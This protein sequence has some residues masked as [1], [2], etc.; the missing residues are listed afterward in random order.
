MG[1]AAP[2][3]KPAAPRP[4]VLIDAAPGG[5]AEMAMCIVAA[6]V[7]VLLLLS[8]C[9][10]AHVVTPPDMDQAQWDT[11]EALRIPAKQWTELEH[12]GVGQIRVELVDELPGKLVGR[13]HGDRPCRPWVEVERGAPATVLAHEIGHI[14]LALHSPDAPSGFMAPETDGTNL[15]IVEEQRAL[16][17]AGA[18]FLKL[19]KRAA[20]RKA[21]KT[22]TPADATP[23]T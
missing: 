2:P 20:D 5:L 8:G 9:A 10:T 3:P 17:R 4:G 23:A 22:A 21:R 16:M 19:C 6:V 12:G 18:V 14:L 1:K 11:V 15:E 7:S 13:A